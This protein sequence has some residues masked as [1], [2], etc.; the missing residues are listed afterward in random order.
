MDVKKLKDTYNKI[1]EDY[2]KDHAKDTWDDDFIDYFSKEL[3][4][5]AR[6]LDLGCGPG[7]DAVKLAKKGLKVYGFDLSE[8]LLKIASKQLPE[9]I[10]TQGDM[11]E[12]FPY[13]DDF[14]DGVF[15]KASLLHIPRTK[16]E[17]VLKEILRVLKR[18]G[19]LHITVKKGTGERE[20]RG[21]DYGY[22]YERFF[23][24]WQ[25]EEIKNIFNK[26]SL[27][28]LREGEEI[29]PETKSVWLKFLLKKP[30]K[31]L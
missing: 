26:H 16:I 29:N 13:E 11:L 22:E 17:E 2:T 27:I 23:S 6:I 24:Y 30:S 21:N 7:T 8:E 1:A 12:R 15:A 19:V 20:V 10:F 3:F 18:N 14:F 28:L 4:S 9:G 5:G 25:P 31:I